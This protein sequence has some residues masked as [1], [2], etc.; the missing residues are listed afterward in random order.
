MT[1]FQQ[2]A[3][4]WT[5][6]WLLAV[7][8]W[9]RT[10]PRV[11]LGGLVSIIGLVGAALLLEWTSLEALGLSGPVSWPKTLAF[12]VGGL[13]VMVAWSPVADRIATRFFPRPPDLKAFRALQQSPAK[14]A[15]GLV[16]AWIFGGVFEEL[17]LR[18]VVLQ[19]VDA[20]L[21]GF[22]PQAVSVG[23]GVLAAAFGG[24]ILHLYQGPRAAF[25]IAQL[26]VLFGLVFVLSGHDLWAVIL[27]H[28]LY[29]TVAFVRFA[30]KKSKYADLDAG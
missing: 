24:W 13:A 9:F 15:M 6:L 25:I 18:A 27:C 4:A 26:S 7:G 16:F 17:A 28:G 29:D 3:L 30:L 12:A 19:A 23:A 10:S 8:L 14:L 21:G 11:M 2:V 20:G 22:T 5:A 1:L